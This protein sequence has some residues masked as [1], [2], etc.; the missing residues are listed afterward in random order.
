MKT[1]RELLELAAKA[2]GYTVNACMQ[3]KRDALV[4][5]ENAGLWMESGS[6]NWNP[7]KNSGQALDL[8]V[9]L[10]MGIDHNH[11]A[12]EIF[13]SSSS[14]AN[15]RLSAVEEFDDEVQREAATRRAIVRAAAEIGG[16]R[17]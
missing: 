11:S 13:W 1:D 14:A 9:R 15:Q 2:A 3:E 4:G 12:D 16:K 5:R 6:T 7:L 17:L 10:R 8:A